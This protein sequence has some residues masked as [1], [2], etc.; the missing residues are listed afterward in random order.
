[1]SESDM[2]IVYFFFFFSSEC[3]RL[4][5]PWKIYF[6]MTSISLRDESNRPVRQVIK[7]TK[8]VAFYFS[9]SVECKSQVNAQLAEAIETGDVAK[10]RTCVMI[11]Q[12]NSHKAKWT[13]E[14]ERAAL[15][16]NP[17]SEEVRYT[18]GYVAYGANEDT[19]YRWFCLIRLC[20]CRRN[21]RYIFRGFLDIEM[22]TL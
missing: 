14:T 18:A 6:V 19:H 8:Y 3:F 4:V 15:F 5:H 22:V 17:D 10:V 13:Q 21:T 20:R 7:S 1:M 2:C 16:A 9:F 12:M 11:Q